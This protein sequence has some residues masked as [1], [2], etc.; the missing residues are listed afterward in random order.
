MEIGREVVS[1]QAVYARGG[2]DALN[3][4]IIERS[5][6]DRPFL[7]LLMKPD[8]APISGNIAET[9]VQPRTAPEAHASFHIRQTDPDGGIVRRNAWGRQMK[10]ASGELLFVGSDIDEARFYILRLVRAIWGAGVL[11]VV[12]GLAG[13][14]LIS[15]NVSRSM[16]GAEPRWWRRWR[17]EICTHGSRCSG[18]RRRV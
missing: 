9:P 17:A 14:I 13:G 4:A 15:R 6:G 10:F 18:V 2:V 12:L 11:V 8:G 1:L 7:Y 5:V 3:Q 16:A